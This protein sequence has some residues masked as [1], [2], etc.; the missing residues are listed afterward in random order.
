MKKSQLLKL[1]ALLLFSKNNL[2]MPAKPVIVR[3][4]QKNGFVELA[5]LFRKIE[6]INEKKELLEF[7]YINLND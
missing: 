6:K 5:N 4:L 7:F 2:P 1:K 3:E